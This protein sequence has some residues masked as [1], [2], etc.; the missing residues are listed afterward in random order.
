MI[1]KETMGLAGAILLALPWI[2]DFCV[3][4][5]AARTARVETRMDRIKAKL[6]SQY[7]TWLGSAKLFD[8]LLTAFGLALLAGSF[9]I[10][11]Y[12]VLNT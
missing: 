10:G 12:V 3:R 9:G 4:K 8:L 6:S 11:L 1:A 5:K 7:D 2:R